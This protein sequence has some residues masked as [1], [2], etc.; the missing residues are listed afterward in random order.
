MDLRAAFDAVS[1]GGDFVDRAAFVDLDASAVVRPGT[2]RF[3]RSRRSA[4]SRRVI[5]VVADLTR[6]VTSVSPVDSES[7]DSEL[8][9]RPGVLVNCHS[10]PRPP[11]R[12]HGRSES[13]YY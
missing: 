7:S 1:M 9:D 4:V 12:N 10:V 2:E 6:T 3:S 8:S 11:T 5:E 13:R